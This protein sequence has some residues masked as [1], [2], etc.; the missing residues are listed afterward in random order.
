MIQRRLDGGVNFFRSWME[1]A[2][3]FGAADGEYWLGNRALYLLTHNHVTDLYVHLADLVG[4]SRHATYSNFAVS[5]E[6]SHFRLD[7][8]SFTGNAGE[9]IHAN[10]FTVCVCVCLVSVCLCVYLFLCLYVY[11]L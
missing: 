11:G 7:I 10:Q 9:K 3:G 1:Y 8:G 5:S 2:R 6:F 4:N